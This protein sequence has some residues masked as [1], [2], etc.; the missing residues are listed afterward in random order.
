ME[1][2]PEKLTVHSF[3][4]NEMGDGQVLINYNWNS[5]AFEN[6]TCCYFG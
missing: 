6:F 1:D 3:C 4:V 2:E 5:V